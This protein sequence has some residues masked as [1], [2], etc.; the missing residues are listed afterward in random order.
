MSEIISMI[1]NVGFPIVCCIVMAWYVNKS[2]EDNRETLDKLQESI[3]NNTIAITR[4]CAKLG[5]D[6]IE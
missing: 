3:N 5:V 1:S 6:E 4:L 2:A